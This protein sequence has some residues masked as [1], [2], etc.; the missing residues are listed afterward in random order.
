MVVVS[1]GTADE[2][3]EKQVRPEGEIPLARRELKS[4]QQIESILMSSVQAREYFKSGNLSTCHDTITIK[5]CTV[6]S[7][8]LR[9]L[10]FRDEVVSQS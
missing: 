8:S 1:A 9:F 7:P 6:H 10:S 4:A 5:I 2:N 3:I